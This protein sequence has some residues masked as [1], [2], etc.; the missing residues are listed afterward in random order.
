MGSTLIESPPSEPDAGRSVVEPP[1][2]RGRI[3]LIV[4]GSLA[5]G[6]VVTLV[7]DLIVFAGAKEDV[8]T[9]V[10]LLAFALGW[11][12]LA[13]LS[14]RRTDQP[15]QWA[16]VPAGV[17]AVLGLGHLV[18]APSNGALE[19]FG[20]LWP[21]PL[22]GLVVWMI[23]QSRR[24]LHTRT[25]PWLVYPLFGVLAVAAVGGGY[26]RVAET[27][28][29]NTFAMPGRLVDVGGHKLH[30][31]CTGA[32]SPTV[33]LEP[34]LG[35]PSSMMSGWIA[36]AVARDTRVC[37]YD[38]A[39]RGWSESAPGAQDGVQVATDLHTLLR[40]AGEKGPFVLGGHSAG[41]AYVLN[42]AKLYPDQVAGVVL[43]DSMHPEQYT[44]LSSW[45]RFYDTFRRLSALLPSLSR[46][47]AGRLFSQV[48]YG[49]LPP[50][51][52]N[53][54]RAFLSTARNYRSVRDEFAELRTAL[55]QAQ[56]LTS[57]GGKP[58][59]V[60]TARRGAEGGPQWLTLQDD[61]AK[62]S[63]NSVHR[64]FNA[65]HQT[66]TEDRKDA[67]LSSQAI[68]DL[69]ESIRVGRPAA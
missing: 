44:R 69:V 52:R 16:W 25:R 23:A 35:E 4:A 43:L 2:P 56:S 14:T 63:T 65:T 55:K 37:V 18:L 20:W 45:P 47:G 10:S 28:D 24:Q 49:G 39:G 40:R 58:L 7:L 27:R 61:L 48:N 19:A 60:V 41:G 30:I 17:M 34:G 5:T 12:T 6:V 31:N 1:R 67:A 11:A 9:G 26:E 32:G 33:I 15:Q 22:L 36:P 57:L 3:G 54:E 62:L 38:R 68:R 42:F 13:M 64:V 51:A 50:R 53:E 29:R 21:I 46:L 8:I 66:L 59:M